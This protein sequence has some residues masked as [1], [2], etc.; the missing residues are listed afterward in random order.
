MNAAPPRPPREG[1]TLTRRPGERFTLGPEFARGG[2]GGVHAITGE[3]DT[4]VKIYLPGLAAAR[5]A[6]VVAMVEA[7]AGASNPN[8]A[9][10]TAVAY[11]AQGGFAGFTMR[12]VRGRKPI[13]ELYAA[14]S[15]RT[16]FPEATYP[17]LV[18]TAGNVAR[19]MAQIHAAGCV[20][21]DVN[22]S[23][24]LVGRD[25]TVAF[26]DA[27]SFQFER[28]GETW[29]C[30]VGV[31]EFTPPE[32]QGRSLEGVTR[33]RDQDGFG[34]AVLVFHILMM[35]RHP[36]NGRW[37]AAGEMP[38]DKAIAA[39]AF[40]YSRTRAT[41]MLPPPGVP[42]LGDLP[43]GIAAAFERAF[44]P[45]GEASRPG[46]AEWARLLDAA[47]TELVGCAASPTHHKFTTAQSCPWCRMEAAYPGFVAFQTPGMPVDVDALVRRVLAMRDPGDEPPLVERMPDLVLEP[48]EASLRRRRRKRGAVV[49]RRICGWAFWLWVFAN[50]MA[51]T[52]WPW[53]LFSTVTLGGWFAAKAVAKH[54]EATSKA[55]VKAAEQAFAR[56][57]LE[58]EDAASPEPFRSLR[59]DVLRISRE[60]KASCDLEKREIADL[61]GTGRDAQMIRHLDRQSIAD[62]DIQG[63]GDGLKQTLASFNVETAADVTPAVLGIVPGFGP[64]RIGRMLEWRKDRESAFV[65]VPGKGANP[66][67]LARHRAKHAR[68]RAA[69]ATRI[70]RGIAEM[71]RMARRLRAYKTAHVQEALPVWTALCQAR[72]DAEA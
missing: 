60:V 33:T 71:D 42:D 1:S 16:A 50:G 70:R 62:A 2:E 40:A 44:G 45:D 67:E 14:T 66:D 69:D 57:A 4:V 51:Q 31:P 54:G 59:R 39:H 65:H 64:S 30:P 6:K 28:G 21:G 19:T 10:P 13:H 18:R 61:N 46:A 41:G 52:W 36:F 24:I 55:A 68:Q 11:D 17:M 35:G 47:E 43:A 34:L 26:I 32:L 58:W 15:R 7:G 8:V 22:H 48:S 25:A 72:S 63:L 23:G 49:I 20:V 56:L 5:R 53:A 38:T 12:R 37:T 3:P 27:D 9:F 29:G